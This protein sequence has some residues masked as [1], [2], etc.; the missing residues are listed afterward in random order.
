MQDH[1]NVLAIPSPKIVSRQCV[2]GIELGVSDGDDKRDKEQLQAEIDQYSEC[3]VVLDLAGTGF[4]IFPVSFIHCHLSKKSTSCFIRS[5][6]KKLVCRIQ[7]NRDNVMKF[8][9]HSPGYRRLDP[10]TV[11]FIFLFGLLRDSYL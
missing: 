4:Y 6:T 11:M 10:A 2:A 8:A 3:P 1:P 9:L 5:L 7:P